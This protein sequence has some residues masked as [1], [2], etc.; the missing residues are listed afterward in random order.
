[1][2]TTQFLNQYNALEQ[3]SEIIAQMAAIGDGMELALVSDIQQYQASQ[4]DITQMSSDALRS[5]LAYFY[6]VVREF[7]QAEGTLQFQ[8]LA[9][10]PWTVSSGATLL[11]ASGEVFTQGNSIGGNQGVT[12]GT[13]SVAQGTTNT[14]TGT[15]N[16]YISVAVAGIDL[17]TISLQI[18]GQTILPLVVGPTGV[19]QPIGGFYAFYYSGTLFIKI[20]PGGNV[21]AFDG[22]AYSVTYITCDGET[23]NVPANSFTGYTT[24]ILSTD[25]NQV[26][27]VLTNSAIANGASS[28]QNSDLINLLRYWL[29][30]KGTISKPSDYTTWYNLQPQ[31]GDCLIMGDFDLWAAKGYPPGGQTVTSK[32]F[33]SLLDKVA[34]PIT[35]PG[36]TYALDLALAPYRDLGV[37]DYVSY[38]AVPVYLN[39]EFRYIS[40]QNIPAFQA[41][42]TALAQQYF[43]LTQVRNWGLSLFQDVSTADIM[44]GLDRANYPVGLEIVPHYFTSIT[45]VGSG[46]TNFSFFPGLVSIG[47]ISIVY[48]DPGNVVHVVRETLSPGTVTPNFNN[49]A[50]MD[51]TGNASATSKVVGTHDYGTGLIQITL[52]SLA[53]SPWTPGGSFT[54]DCP[55]LY[56]GKITAGSVG[57]YRKLNSVLF[58]QYQ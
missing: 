58:T 48:T 16:G 18:N 22:Q 50:F 14:V 8:A 39:L 57:G 56:K 53:V 35:D 42:A 9:N 4:I 12:E 7:S 55:A 30:V 44:A 13:I 31:V 49:Y 15:Y 24:P 20:F 45:D 28:P 51:D 2:F 38:P 19:V 33:A 5:L 3:Q 47:E 40:V 26:Q 43:D 27:F 41:T 1:M 32:M 11:T 29:F 46:Q 10:A 54:F 21:P 23:G 17:S 52:N 6:V 36:V 37:T 25:G 34:A